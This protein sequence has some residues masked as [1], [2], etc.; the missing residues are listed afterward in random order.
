M[1]K[2][3]KR[4]E[5]KENYDLLFDSKT[6]LFFTEVSGREEKQRIKIEIWVIINKNYYYID[7]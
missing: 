7:N 3:R 4:G 1:K 5:E 6:D 2:M